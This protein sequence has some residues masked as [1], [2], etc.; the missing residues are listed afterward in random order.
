M[1][2]RPTLNIDQVT[3]G[4]AGWDV[5]V[6]NATAEIKTFVAGQPLA[7]KVYTVASGG[8]QLPAAASYQHCQAVI[9]DPASGKSRLVVSD[10]TNWRYAGDDSI[11]L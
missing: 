11:A 1:P 2:T 3:P 5:T 7:L 8:S 9:S 10:G 4:Q 6:N